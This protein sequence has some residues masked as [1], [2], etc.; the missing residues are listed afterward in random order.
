MNGGRASPQQAA[1]KAGLSGDAGAAHGWGGT[2]F[3]GM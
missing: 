3:E 2:Q 1:E